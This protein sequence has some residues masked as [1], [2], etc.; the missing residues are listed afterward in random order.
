MKIFQEF[1]LIHRSVKFLGFHL[2]K[3]NNYLRAPIIKMNSY[4]RN[5]REIAE[6]AHKDTSSANQSQTYFAHLLGI[7]RH[8]VTFFFFL[9]SYSDSSRPNQV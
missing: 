5:S 4:I 2:S 3:I 7:V 1:P 6:T 8:C 9:M